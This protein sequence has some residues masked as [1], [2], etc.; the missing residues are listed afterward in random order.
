M[1]TLNISQCNA[2]ISNVD[3]EMNQDK[4]IMEN[5][6]KKDLDRVSII[7]HMIFKKARR[8]NC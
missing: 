7:D 6:E 5:P 4:R 3:S 8:F 1:I 2:L